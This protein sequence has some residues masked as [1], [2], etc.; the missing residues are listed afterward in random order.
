MLENVGHLG[1]SEGGDNGAIV[2]GGCIACLSGL[3]STTVV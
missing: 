1:T 3:R 2:L